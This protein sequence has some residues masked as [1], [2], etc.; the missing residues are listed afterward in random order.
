MRIPLVS[1]H[2]VIVGILDNRL[3]SGIAEVHLF[4]VVHKHILFDVLDSLDVATLVSAYRSVEILVG[5]MGDDFVSLFAFLTSGFVMVALDV[6]PEV[7]PS[8]DHFVV[9]LFVLFEFL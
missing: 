9:G 6:E 5:S 8:I 1:C 3:A 7:T 4:L 2:K